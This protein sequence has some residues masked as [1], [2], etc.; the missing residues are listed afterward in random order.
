[1]GGRGINF[2][3]VKAGLVE[4]DSTRRLPDAE[5]V[6]AGRTRRGLV[7]QRVL[8]ASDVADV[9]LFLASRL[10]DLVQGETVTV[11]GGSALHA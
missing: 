7:G 5:A 4:T 11:D 8:E 9:V 1:L 2:N 10:S 3:V 6:F